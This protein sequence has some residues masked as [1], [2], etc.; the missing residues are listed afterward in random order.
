MA[1]GNSF[2][3]GKLQINGNAMGGLQSA[4]LTAEED[5]E[6]TKSIGETWDQPKGLAKRWRLSA[7]SYYDPTNA[8]QAAIMLAKGANGGSL[9]SCS[10]F[11]KASS[12]IF[13]G[14][15]FVTTATISKAKGSF[16]MLDAEILGRGPMN[17]ANT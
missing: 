3:V 17:T 7:R 2:T 6:D 1:T 13:Y 5:V 10:M 11:V 14:S 9:T 16:D 12:E 4:T 15:A 8:A